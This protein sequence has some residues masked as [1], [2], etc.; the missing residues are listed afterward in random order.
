MYFES[1]L[2]VHLAMYPILIFGDLWF[3][4]LYITVTNGDQAAKPIIKS[5]PTVEPHIHNF[6]LTQ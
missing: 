4:K 6:K 2:Y 5:E 1:Y 3:K